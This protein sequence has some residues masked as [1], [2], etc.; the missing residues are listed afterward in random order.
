MGTLCLQILACNLFVIVSFQIQCE[1]NSMSVSFQIHDT[2]ANQQKIVSLSNYPQPAL[3][4]R[5][6]QRLCLST[7]QEYEGGVTLNV[8]FKFM[9]FI[10]RRFRP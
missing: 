5:S 7:A 1:M 9:E 6:C 2:E 3:H 8:S 4:S 10:E